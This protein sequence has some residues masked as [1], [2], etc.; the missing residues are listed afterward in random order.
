MAARAA[1]RGRLRGTLAAVLVATAAASSAL[2][3]QA[4][5]QQQCR[6]TKKW[7]AG[8]CRYPGDINRIKAQEAR[9][10]RRLAEKQRQEAQQARARER[11][12][13]EQATK[14]DTPQAWK[15]YLAEHVKGS[16]R[17]QAE[18]RIGELEAE[19]EHEAEQTPPPEPPLE[20]KP[21]P[22]PSMAATENACSP[23]AR[24]PRDLL[25]APLWLDRTR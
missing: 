9:E 6:G 24:Q 25:L 3:V 8:K 18:R 15:K 17:E 14:E 7:Y 23:P 1:V 5:E 10:A 16:C 11:A 21:P 2:P 4:Q 22:T 12:D 19:K 20:P 13:C